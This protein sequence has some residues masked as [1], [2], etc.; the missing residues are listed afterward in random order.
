MQD[1]L[2]SEDEAIGFARAY[3][4]MAG[5]SRELAALLHLAKQPGSSV[6]ELR[7]ASLKLF[8]QSYELELALA[9]QD[10]LGGDYEFE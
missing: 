8:D 4:L 10:P 9:D 1:K 7:D 5:M 3:E 2:I 6:K